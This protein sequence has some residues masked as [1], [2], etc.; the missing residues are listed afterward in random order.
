MRRTAGAVALA[1]IVTAAEPT[2]T[3]RRLAASQPA[4]C[5]GEPRAVSLN[6]TLEDLHGNKVK[7][8]TFDGK[9]LLL[10][11]WATWCAPCKVE[12]P[13]LVELQARYADAGLQVIGIAVDEPPEKIAS[14]M[15]GAR[16]NYPVLRSTDR[17]LDAFARVTMLP[18]SFVIGRDRRLCSTHVGA[19]SP[20]ALERE[21]RLLLQSTR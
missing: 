16:I 11:F 14:F 10:N 20:A 3:V 6:H 5:E 17:V 9:V 8:A 1:C 21:L 18:T 4:A 15:T 12:I 2:T 7:L 13:H 19:V